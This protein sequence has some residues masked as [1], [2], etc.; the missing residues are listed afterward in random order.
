MTSAWLGVLAEAERLTLASALKE[1]GPVVVVV[2]FL[3]FDLLARSKIGKA[4][5]QE[6]ESTKNIKN[7]QIERKDEE[8]KSLKSEHA[9]QIETW[10][11][12]LELQTQLASPDVVENAKAH[13]VGLEEILQADREALKEE[14]QA[15]AAAEKSDKKSAE[16]LAKEK[17]LR[18]EHEKKLEEREESIAKLEKE[19]ARMR[20]AI[21]S[22]GVKDLSDATASAT[23]A[24]LM[25]GPLGDAYAGVVSDLPHSIELLQS[26]EYKRFFKGVSILR[27]LARAPHQSGQASDALRNAADKSTEI[28]RA[29]RKA[30]TDAT[31]IRDSV[32]EAAKSA[33][34][35]HDSV[36]E[37]AK[38]VTAM[39]RSVRKAVEDDR[40]VREQGRDAID[41]QRKLDIRKPPGA[42]TS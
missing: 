1:F 13:I 42:S 36:R 10:Q 5:T 21:A 20:D 11:A 29:A 27:R 19:L 15:R 9:K 38:S 35:I 40:K 31:A 37:A 26:V 32:R 3:V 34:A 4:L 6:L 22:Q 2:V 17:G 7:A 33:T 41:S 28:N 12:K 39:D 14:K 8:I 23:E 25:S 24:A 18:E 16:D 30:A